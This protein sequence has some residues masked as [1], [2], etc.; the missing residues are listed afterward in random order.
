MSDYQTFPERIR[1]GEFEVKIE[2]PSKPAK[3]RPR[4]FRLADDLVGLAAGFDKN[5]VALEA[6][7]RCGFGFVEVGAATPLPQPGNPRPRLFRLAADLVGL[8]A[9][10]DLYEAASINYSATVQRYR[11][12]QHDAEDRFKFELLADLGILGHEKADKLY[13]MAWERSHSE[14][15]E[16]VYHTAEELSELLS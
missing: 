5:A 4:L 12:A 8:A 10:L 14:G 2:Y 15:Y 9:E 13:E 16:S 11:E 7:A 6:L 3:P 1:A